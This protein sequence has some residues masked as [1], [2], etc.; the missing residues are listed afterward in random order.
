M[1]Q[2]YAAGTPV[3]DEGE[4]AAVAEVATANILRK[5]FGLVIVGISLVPITTVGALVGGNVWWTV[6][7]AWA[8]GI[9]L[10][11][12]ILMPER[13]RPRRSALK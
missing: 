12:G 10:I 11:A 2:P 5:V 6:G 1:P 13:M 9:I 4:A 7:F 3:S 8:V